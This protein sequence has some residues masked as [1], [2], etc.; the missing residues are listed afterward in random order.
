MS[1]FK[2]K[3]HQ[4]RFRWGSAQTPQGELTALPRPLAGF[5]GPISKGEG[6]GAEGK[7]G[8]G[9]EWRGEEGRGGDTVPEWYNQKV[10]TLSPI[11]D[12]HF[13]IPQRDIE[14]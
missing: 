9:K 7:E 10:V 11:A 3:M 5:K 6:R 2:A 14:S 12:T 13:T 1:D 4:I 8:R